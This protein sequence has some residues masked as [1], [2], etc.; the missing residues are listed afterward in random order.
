MLNVCQKKNFFMREKFYYFA[1]D[2]SFL[3]LLI[4]KFEVFGNV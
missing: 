2:M 4:L 1:R 3:K